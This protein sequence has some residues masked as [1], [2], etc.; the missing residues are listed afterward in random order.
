MVYDWFDEEK[1]PV[2]DSRK[3]SP[4]NLDCKFFYP[5]RLVIV[6]EHVFGES[7]EIAARNFQRKGLKLFCEKNYQVS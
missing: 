2:F 3:I 7:I 6:N 4:D 5:R 1:E